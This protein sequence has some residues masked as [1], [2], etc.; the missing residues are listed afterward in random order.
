MEDVNPYGVFD[1]TAESADKGAEIK[2]EILERQRKN[3]ASVFDLQGMGCM[4]YVVVEAG[5]GG[6]GGG[7]SLACPDCSAERR[8]RG[9]FGRLPL[10]YSS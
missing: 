7:L 1:M 3:A 8:S 9:G 6:W 5:L 2:T 10:A 4:K